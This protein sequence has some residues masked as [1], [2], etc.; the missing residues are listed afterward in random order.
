LLGTYSY[1]LGSRFEAGTKA[2][3]KASACDPTENGG[4]CSTEGRRKRGPIDR[5]QPADHSHPSVRLR[6]PI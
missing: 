3:K 5:Q 1:L 4:G 6:L 2:L